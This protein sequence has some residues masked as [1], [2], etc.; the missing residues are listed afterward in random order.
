MQSNDGDRSE[1]PANIT[2]APLP[3]AATTLDDRLAGLPIRAMRLLR[4]ARRAIEAGHADQAD[5]AL[6]R[7]QPMIGEHA[8]FLRLLGVTRHLQKRRTEALAAFRRAL[9]LTP[10]DPLVLTNFGSTLRTSGDHAAAEATL[11][12]ACA[13]APELAAAWYN[14]GLALSSDSRP[15]EALDAYAQA[16]RCEPRHLNARISHADSLRTLGRIAEAAAQYRHVLRES[17]RAV[18]AWSKLANLKTVALSAEETAALEHARRDPMLSADDRSTLGFALIKAL[19]DQGRYADACSAIL[20]VNAIRHRQVHWNAVSFSHRADAIAAAFARAPQTLSPARMGEEVIFIVSM[21]RSGSTLTE[22]ILASHAEVEGAGELSDLAAVIDRES[23]RTGIAFPGWV[24]QAQP[25]D[26]RRLGEA[27]LE[28]TARWRHSHPRFTDKALSN[29]L[30]IGAALAMLPGAHFV[31]VHRDP[32][33]TCLSCFRQWFHRGHGYTYDI[34]DLASF[35]RDYDR[36][37]RIWKTRYPQRVHDLVYEDLLAD[38]EHEIRSLLAFCELPFDAACL[39]F[40]ETKRGVR[41]LSS[42]QVRQPLRRDTARAHRY[43]AL[44]EPLRAALARVGGGAAS[45]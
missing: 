20:E 12:R 43:D 13:L 24:A 8:E 39:H 9:E 29:W 38:P 11:R 41:T 35:W 19:E 14:L 25:A 18:R 33:E 6:Q 7:A 4:E 17:P 22:Q 31:N 44:L 32:I 10:S 27:Y 45:Q 2:Q 21:P 37:G 1:A 5:Q 28:R 15:A 26:W 3:Y 30:Y 23:Q 34:D 40:H 16:L 42:A 36:L